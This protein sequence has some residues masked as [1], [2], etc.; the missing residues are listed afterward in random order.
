M[1]FLKSSKRRSFISE[2][3]YI[4]LNVLFAVAI[5]V[6]VLVVESPLLAFALVLLGKWRVMAVRPRYW[7]VNLQAN[8]VDII[9]GLSIVVLL[10]AASGA[11]IMQAV[12]TLLYIGW[13]LFIKPRS[14]R[15]F[16]AIQAGTA[17]FLGVSA[18]MIESPDWIASLVVVGM[19]LIG[20]SAARHVLSNYDEAHSSFYS[21][22]WGFLFAEFGWLTYHWAFAYSL[23]GVGNIKLSQTALIALALS[24]L[25]ERFYSSYARHGS[26]QSADVLLPSVLAVSIIVMLLFVLNTIGGTNSI[27]ILP[28]LVFIGVIDSLFVFVFNKVSNNAR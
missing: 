15:M 3:I 2:S 23:P 22:V 6:I 19:W 4:A 24:F 1:D 14:K 7:F 16:I 21:F 26:I 28:A 20:F 9:V 13:L 17:V 12:L 25:V 8:L 10:Y 5:L 11:V 27:I 18:L